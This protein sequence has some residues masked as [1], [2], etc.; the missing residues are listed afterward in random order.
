MD[1]AHLVVDN[2]ELRHQRYAISVIEIDN[3]FSYL[4][5]LVF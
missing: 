4:T 1:Q 2:V 3:L 5:K